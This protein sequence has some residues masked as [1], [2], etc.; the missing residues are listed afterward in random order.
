MKDI[1]FSIVIPSYNCES[2][3]Q[4]CI[5]SVLSQTYKNF[6]IIVVDDMSTDNSV[7]IIK[8]LLRTDDTLIVNW[9]KRYSGGTRNEGIRKACGDY[10]ICIDCDDWLKDDRVLEDINNSLNGEDVMYLG[11]SMMKNNNTTDMILSIHNKYEAQHNRYPAPWLKCVKRS[12][13]KEAP[14]PEGTMFEDRMQ[15]ILLSCVANTFTSLGR[16]THIWNRN[17]PNSMTFNPTWKWY[18]FEYCGELYRFIQ[19]LD[20]GEFKNELISELKNYSN[21]CREMVD[22]L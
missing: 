8:K 5:E 2:S 15:D 22:E 14:F 13:Y 6:E 4:R 9:N 17:N 11:F 21:S 12:V 1:T 3:I 16:T 7:E 19:T 10:I 18:R 20:D